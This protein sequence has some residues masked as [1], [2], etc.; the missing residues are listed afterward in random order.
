MG[1]LDSHSC[2]AVRRYYTTSTGQCR[3]GQV[4]SWPLYPYYPVYLSPSHPSFTTINKNQRPH[5]RSGFQH[6]LMHPLCWAVVRRGLGEKGLAT[7]HIGDKTTHTHNVSGDH[8]M[9]QKFHSCLA[10]S[11]STLFLLGINCGH[12]GICVLFSFFHQNLVIFS[13][14]TFYFLGYIYS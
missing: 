12:K 2:E 6:H 11:R 7:S 5:G 1:S 10:L 4:G 13:V 8:L 14:Q 9:G 3:E